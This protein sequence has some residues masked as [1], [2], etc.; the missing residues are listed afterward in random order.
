MVTG[1]L[2]GYR[3]N[4]ALRKWERGREVWMVQLRSEVRDA[5]RMVRPWRGSAAQ[6]TS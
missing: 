5:L 4:Q 6:V 1:L 2:I 3:S